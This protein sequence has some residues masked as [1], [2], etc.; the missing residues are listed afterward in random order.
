MGLG[1]ARWAISARVGPFFAIL[2]V[3]AIFFLWQTP[4]SFSAAFILSEPHPAGPGMIATATETE[5]LQACRKGNP[6]AQKAVFDQYADAM[7]LLCY[8]YLPLREEA[9]EAMMDG[10]YQFFKNIDRF[11]WRGEGSMKAWLTRIMVNQC[12]MQLRK[13]Q[14]IP[15]ADI[16]VAEDVAINEDALGRLTV[17]EIIGLVHQL[18]V[19]YRTVFNLYFFEGMTGPEIAS[20]LGISEN[21]VK[22]QL[23]KARTALQKELSR[24]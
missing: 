12:L 6:T 11:T 14:P 8:R 24:Y 1:R 3:C 13:K 4:F 15:M 16:D 2:R 20:L 19:G 21:T 17:R 10:F 18:P 9:Q 22:S 5:L 7:I 23:R